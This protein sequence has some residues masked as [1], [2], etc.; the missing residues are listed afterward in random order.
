[1]QVH[2]RNIGCNLQRQLGE[3][4]PQAGQAAG[5][6]LADLYLDIVR[7]ALADARG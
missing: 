1:M 7:T 3:L 4:L 5:G 2:R 6:R